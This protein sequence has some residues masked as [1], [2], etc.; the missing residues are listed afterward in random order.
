MPASIT[1]GP[2]P[3]PARATSAPRD[4][5]AAPNFG[6]ALAHLEAGAWMRAFTELAVLANGGHASAARIALMMASRG[7]AMFGG[8]FHA[9]PRDLTRWKQVAGG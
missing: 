1:L 6:V 7:G 4:P 5:A 3:G 2:A 8:Y 9:T